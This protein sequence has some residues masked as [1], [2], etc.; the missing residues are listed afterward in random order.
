MPEK[1]NVL[2]FWMNVCRPIARK[3]GFVFVLQGVF[4]TFLASK[5]FDIYLKLLK[6]VDIAHEEL[7]D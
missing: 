5:H 7:H 1:G 4:G 6:L 3:M 2:R